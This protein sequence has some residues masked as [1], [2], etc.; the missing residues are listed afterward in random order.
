MLRIGQIDCLKKI[1]LLID[2]PEI[3][4]MIPEKEVSFVREVFIGNY[5]CAYSFIHKRITILRIV[6]KGTQYGK[7]AI[8]P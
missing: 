7:L 5:K 8:Y 1:E 3:G 6:P 2:F 4:N